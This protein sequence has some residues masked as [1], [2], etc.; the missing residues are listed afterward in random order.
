MFSNQQSQPLLDVP[1]LFSAY[2]CR[3][4][5]CITPTS[6]SLRAPV[7]SRPPD[8]L[9]WS[10]L[11]TWYT[12]AIYGGY[13]N[14]VD[15][16]LQPPSDYDSVKIPDGL[17]VVVDTVLPKM[18]YLEIAGIIELDNGRDHYLEA[19]IIFINGGQ[20]IVG[21][22]NDPILTNV[23]ISITGKKADAVDY[24]LPNKFTTIAFKSIGVFGG[25]DIHGQPR[26]VCWTTLNKTAYAGQSQL[27]LKE[28]VDWKVNEQIVVSTTT[29]IATDTE[30]FTIVNVSP[31]RLTL[32]LD[33]ALQ[34]DH[35]SFVENSVTIAAAVGLLSRN[36]KIIGAE[37][38]EQESD[39]YGFSILV[40][41]YSNFD[42]NGILMY[43]K[44]YARLSNVEFY[45]PGKFFR[46]TSDDS[47]YGIIMSNL[48]D[49]N[50]SRP[51]YVRSCAFHH[52]FTA[53]IGIFGSNSIP[54]E[55]NVIYRTLD[56]AIWVEGNSNIIRHNLIALNYWGSSFITWDAQYDKTF[57]GSITAHLAD[58][59]VIESNFIA[60]AERSGIFFRGD[61]C[62]GES[63]GP[64]LNHSIKYNTIH[65]AL[66]GVV[67][68]PK[69]TFTHITC[70][71]F[72]HYT[73]FK[74]T[75]YAIYYQNPH[76]L[77]L[78]SNILIDNQVSI[79]AMVLGPSGLE[80]LTSNK[81]VEVTNTLFV[82]RSASFDCTRDVKPSN[83]NYLM[84]P[85]MVSYGAGKYYL[86]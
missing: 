26:N 40:T 62:P 9:Y 37:Y 55:N 15:G 42:D 33:S 3:F 2:V 1:V 60:G 81:T 85:L 21:W 67:H 70:V 53:A 41:D 58:S 50:Y 16:I 82:G 77:I 23:T 61:I 5:G 12:V 75:N 13:R 56:F 4:V 65:G 7:T 14:S 84:A 35:L 18:K 63:L 76:R 17:Y 6:P 19:N 69:Y 51:T 27:V 31:D 71:S 43:F 52:G 10:N 48:G 80:H 72:S 8:A 24:L 49:Y 73:I 39:L 54:I 59:V 22:E 46:G 79:F 83:L 34:Y 78:D 45:H 47:T 86:I 30:V 66:G 57:W 28:P 74:S 64:G 25:L 29:F 20:L 32:T 68:W 44:G 36:V 38:P 11:T